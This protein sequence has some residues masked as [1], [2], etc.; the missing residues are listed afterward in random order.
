MNIDTS[1]SQSP[2]TRVRSDY[3]PSKNVTF[4]G[5]TGE[6]IA[7]T[8][9]LPD[10]EPRAW[11]LF[12][13]CFTCNRKV[14]GAA[15]TCRALAKQGIACLRFDFTGLGESGGNFADTTFLTNVDDL[16][17]AYEFMDAEYEAPSLLMGHSLGGAAAILAGQ[18]MPKVKAVATIGAPFD[19]AHSIFHFADAIGDIDAHG[20]QTLSIA[21]RDIPSSRDF[22]ETLADINPETYIHKLRKPLLLLHSPTDQTVGIDSAQKIFLVARYPKSLMCLDKADHLMIKPGAPQRAADLIRTWVEAYLP[23]TVAA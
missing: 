18:R 20:T 16:V 14:P 4:T 21:G 22:L 1:Q 2:F 12:A 19:P 13:H 15:R 11:A 8:I 23:A 5:S 3:M 17:A 6:T 10:G 7:A 9:D